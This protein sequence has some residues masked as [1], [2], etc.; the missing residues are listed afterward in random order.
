MQGWQFINLWIGKINSTACFYLCMEGISSTI[1]KNVLRLLSGRIHFFSFPLKGPN[2]QRLQIYKWSG[3]DKS[4]TCRK[5]QDCEHKY[6][7]SVSYFLGDDTT[8]NQANCLSLTRIVPTCRSLS[9]AYHCAPLSHNVEWY[10][11]NYYTWSKYLFIYIF[12]Y[13]KFQIKCVMP[14]Y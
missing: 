9:D 13:G 6:I 10:M 4:V 1:S 11:W 5:V 8:C 14:A 2:L 12:S 3:Q 7:W